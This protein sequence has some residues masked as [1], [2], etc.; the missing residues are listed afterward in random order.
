[1]GQV[2]VI[3]NQ[4]G[5]V[6]KTTTT[7]NLGAVLTE[8]NKEILLVDLDPQG[9]LTFHCGYEP[10]ELEFTIYDALKDEEM[11]DEIILETGFGP[12]LLPAN[13]D[14]AVSEMELMNAV[15]RERRLTAILNPLR[16]KYDLI[17]IDGQP[18][19]GLLTLNAMTAADQA[20]IPISCEYLALRGVDG[21]MKMIKKVQGQLN[22]NLKVNGVLPTMFDR[23]TNHTEWALKQIRDRFEPEIKVYNHIIYR[24]IRFAEAAEAQ[25]PIIYYAKNIPGADGYRNLAREL[26][27]NGTV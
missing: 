24:S 7:L 20:I 11:T 10:E 23:R 22:S 19:L 17:I 14:L 27:K 15:A 16:N 3:A 18:S 2:L 21:L 8:L 13:V 12:E 9:G 25:E 5:G 26:I 4:K 1:M 6:G